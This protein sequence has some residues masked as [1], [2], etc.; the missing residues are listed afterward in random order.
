MQ[1]KPETDPEFDHTLVRFRQRAGKPERNRTYKCIR[2]RAIFSRIRRIRF[3]FCQQLR[4]HF[5]PD[6]SLVFI[7][8]GF[9]HFCL[10]EIVLF[11]EANLRK[12]DVQMC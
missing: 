1:R 6:N 3:A 10:W 11:R 5:K 7:V 9:S 2:Q 12:I 8:D 4:M